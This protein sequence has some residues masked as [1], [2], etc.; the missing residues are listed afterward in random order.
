[1]S[2]RICDSIKSQIASGIYLPGAN[3][4]A[5][6][7]LAEEL[8]VSR[9]TVTVAFEQLAAEGY[10]E[11]SQ[12]KRPWVRH[13]LQTSPPAR[14]PQSKI[15]PELSDF[16]KRLQ[17]L[18]P[19]ERLKG[20]KADFRAGDI[21]GVDFPAATWRKV[22]TRALQI[23]PRA[24]KYD[25]P[26]G[27][28]ELRKALRA[29]MWR[30]RGIRCD[31][32]QIVVVNGSQQG[33]DLC[34]RVFLNTGESVVVE[35]PGYILARNGFEAIGATILPLPVDQDGMQTSLL[36]GIQAKLAYITPSHQYPLGGILPIGRRQE[37]L[38]WATQTGAY[39]VEDDYDG[40]FR[41]DTK[42]TETLH[43]LDTAGRVIYLGTMSK[44]LSPELRLGYLVVPHELTPVFAVAKRL[45]D[46]HSALLQQRALQLFI[47]GGGLERHIRRARRS[48]AQ[49]RARLLAALDHAFGDMVEVVGDAAGLH[50]ALWLREVDAAQEGEVVARAGQAGL[51]LYGI[52]PFY[53]SHD[54][55]KTNRDAGLVMGYA[56][57][58]HREIA[59]GV[60][61]LQNVLDS[62]I[63]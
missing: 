55:R 7:A 47:E 35:D 41:Y 19:P 38:N 60:K 1:M 62:D 25:D 40:E 10:I 59:L 61:L 44:T 56:A 21:S 30:S 63:K 43:S 31:E 58:S 51:G 26:L 39:V 50:V 20:L 8:G 4:P 34:A 57:L 24:L 27:S 54:H 13:G 29:Y 12:G 42:P 46:R 45:T 49:R 16:A 17:A 32:Q 28:L 3:L 23:T 15:A 14:K 36:K 2:S 6:R 48:N 18:A 53:S 11:T 9:S 5:S 52:T 22:M 37:L 33:I